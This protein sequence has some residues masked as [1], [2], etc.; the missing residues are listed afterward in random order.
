MKIENLGV[1]KLYEAATDIETQKKTVKI[2]NPKKDGFQLSQNAA[3][4]VIA[5]RAIA[6]ADPVNDRALADRIAELIARGE[7]EADS[8]SI[9]KKLL[10]TSMF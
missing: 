6:A 10:E 5:R 4:Y 3:E 9:A 2:K 1:Y 8:L 7:Y